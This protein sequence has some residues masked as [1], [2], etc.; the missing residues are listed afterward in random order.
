MSA[1]ALASLDALAKEHG[2]HSSDDLDSLATQFGGKPAEKKNLDSGVFGIPANPVTDLLAGAGGSLA[3]HAVGI[4]DLLRKIPGADKILKYDSADFHK[5]I[6][7]ATPETIPSHVGKFLET[8]GEFLYPSA[9]VSKLT[10]TSNLAARMAAQGA[11]SGGISAAQTGGDKTAALLSGA[12]GAI[13]E[14]LGDLFSYAA[15]GLPARLYKS[16]LKPTRAMMEDHPGIID[17]GLHEHLPVSGE[18]LGKI[19]AGIN[20][21]RQQINQGVSQHAGAT[22]DATKVVPALDQLRNLYAGSANPNMGGGVQAIDAL[23]QEFL[24]AHGAPIPLDVAQTMKINTHRLLKNAY[25]DMKG[26]EV[27]ATKGLARGLK[28]QI[29]TVFPEIAG[30]NQRQSEL[31]GLDEAMQRAVWKMENR[32][33]FPLSMSGA[34]AAGHVI[35]GPEGTALATAGKLLDMPEIKSKIAIALGARGVRNT[36]QFIADRIAAFTSA[37][38]AG[39]SGAME[40][41]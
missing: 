28:E 29:E 35:A 21:L 36:N 41:K 8:A 40:N 11:I 17:A 1:P 24:A 3:Q 22:I 23:K 7:E 12:T 13:G 31:M 4:Y 25:G 2:G 9:A 14:P 27:E 39:M 18:S 33:L 26:A 16:A 10:G 38:N 5:A 6:A 34:A 20:D 32:D 19:E 37:A 15:Q 30:L